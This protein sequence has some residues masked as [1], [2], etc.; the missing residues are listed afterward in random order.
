MGGYKVILALALTSLVVG[1]VFA[2][3]VVRG[4]E[5][6]STPILESGR[7]G[8]PPNHG[9]NMRVHLLLYAT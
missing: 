4:D 6:Q 7:K 2:G 8:N 1:H 5:L 3:A 9:S